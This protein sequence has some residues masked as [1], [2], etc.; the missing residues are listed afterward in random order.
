VSVRVGVS[1]LISDAVEEEISSLR[2]HVRGEVLEDVHVAAVGDGADVG[3]LSL[4]SDVLDSLSSNIHDESVDHGDVVSHASLH[5][6]AAAR[7]EVGSQLGEEGDRSSVLQK[8][9]QVL[10]EAWL[11]QCREVVDHPRSNGDLWQ[12]LNLEVGS[13]GVGQ[14]HVPGEG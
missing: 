10:L 12:H 6:S 4:C 7:L 14:P 11:D 8:A 9:V 1:Q 5:C 2:V 13:E 3:A